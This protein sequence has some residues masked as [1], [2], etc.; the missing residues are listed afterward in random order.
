MGEDEYKRRVHVTN[1]SESGKDTYEHAAEYAVGYFKKSAEEQK[2]T[3]V[4][5]NSVME[6]I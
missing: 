1:L 6:D 3:N 5:V 4:D 2:I